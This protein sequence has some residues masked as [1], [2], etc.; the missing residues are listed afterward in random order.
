MDKEKFLKISV[1]TP[2]YNS[3]KYLEK[4]IQ[5][6]LQQNYP[7]VEHIVM[8]AGS[9]DNTLEILRK[10]PT[11]KWVSEKDKGQSDAMNKAFDRCTG[12]L[13][14]YLNADD[15]F[16]DGAFKKVNEVFNEQ[17][18][19]DFLI[20]GL[21]EMFENDPTIYP[22]K[23]AGTYKKILLHFRY[24]F[25]YNP[26][27]YFYRRSVQEKVGPFP[28]N[29]HYAMDYW[30]LLE[31][32]RISKVTQIN[33]VLGVFFKTGLNKTSNTDP[34]IK[35]SMIA[36]AHAAKYDKGLLRSYQWNL[37]LHRLFSMAKKWKEP[38]KL[39]IYFVFFSRKMSRQEFELLG[40]K[41]AWRQRQ[42]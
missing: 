2:S 9:T 5:S 7:N 27:A 17:P 4:A 37:F 12:D 41:K 30:F 33:Q 15:Y 36:R 3:G 13:V 28:L 29:E 8:D 42:P 6:V 39:C 10:Y 26:V 35:C 38:F 11:V 23:Y 34:G 31:A 1:L 32:L 16:L 20:G 40:F 18:E 25:P 24:G 22:M 21:V 14:V 19:L